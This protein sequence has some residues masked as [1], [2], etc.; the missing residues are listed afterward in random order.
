MEEELR[1]R[2]SKELKDKLETLA[3]SNALSVSSQVRMLIKH[4]LKDA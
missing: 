4:A 3:K 2:I 1:I